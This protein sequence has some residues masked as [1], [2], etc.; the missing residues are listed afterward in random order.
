MIQSVKNN[1]DT[2]H[3]AGRAAGTNF[4]CLLCFRRQKLQ[5]THTSNTVATLKY[6]NYSVLVTIGLMRTRQTP[7]A[8]SVYC[9]SYLLL[10]YLPFTN[11]LTMVAFEH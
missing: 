11:V 6:F 3:I 4:S 9:F 2:T 1:I 5:K 10:L 8:L 7:F